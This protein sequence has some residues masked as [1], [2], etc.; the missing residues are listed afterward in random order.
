MFLSKQITNINM[1]LITANINFDL[2]TDD[3]LK[4]DTG[5]NNK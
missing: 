3:E 2:R 4:T 1:N 5:N